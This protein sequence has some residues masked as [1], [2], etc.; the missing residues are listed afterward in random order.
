MTHVALLG[1]SS[2]DNASYVQPGEDVTS[3][4]RLRLPA[5][6][7][8][9]LLAEDGAQLPDIPAQLDRLPHGATDLIVSIGGNDALGASILLPGTVRT[10]EDALTP[11]ASLP[12]RLAPAHGP[13]T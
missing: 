13:L 9:T 11:L 2:F 1:D 6:L 12:W 7:E 10:I 8:L 3:Q 4:L 5:G